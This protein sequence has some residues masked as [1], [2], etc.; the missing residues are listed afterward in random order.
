MK[1]FLLSSVVMVACGVGDEVGPGGPGPDVNPNR[2]QCSAA[3]QTT[4]SFV[5][6]APRPLVNDAADPRNGLPIQGCWPVGTWTFTASVDNTASVLDLDGD[7]EGDRCGA[8]GTAAPTLETSYSFK[9]ERI[10]D[11][12]SDGLVEKYTYLGTSPN[13]FKVK[14]SEGGGGDCEAAMELVSADRKQWWMLN[15]G[16]CT[17]DEA[18][19]AAE[20]KQ[21]QAFGNRQIVGSGDYTVYLDPQPY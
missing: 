16:I 19:T 8:D 5:Q 7:G 18:R 13:F 14:V 6:G 10:E 4:G 15:P 3:F 9:V 20:L 17:S 1:A 21:C 2:M 11:V 12:L